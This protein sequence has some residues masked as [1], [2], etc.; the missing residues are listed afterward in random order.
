MNILKRLDEIKWYNNKYI[1][2]IEDTIFM[3]LTRQEIIEY[4]NDLLKKSCE[5]CINCE[6]NTIPNNIDTIHPTLWKFKGCSCNYY[7]IALSNTYREN[8]KN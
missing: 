8:Y 7:R 4:Y 3:F 2:K 1:H 5:K 6:N